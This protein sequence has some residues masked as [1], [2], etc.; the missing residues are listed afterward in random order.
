ME[1]VYAH[2]PVFENT[3]YLIRFAEENDAADL[4]EV[5]SDKNALPFFN[6]DNCNGDN[7]YYPTLEAM[8]SA[9]RFWIR[10]YQ[11]RWFVRFA[12]IDKTC[13]KAIG[14]AEL[15]HR[16]SEDAFSGDGVLRLDLKSSYERENVIFD[17]LSLIVPPSFS[18]FSCDEII[19][20]APCYAVERIAAIRRFGFEQSEHLLIGTHDGY[21]YNGYWAI[22]N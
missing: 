21:A 17:L 16:D 20:K 3:R 7:F 5:Y 1:D 8:Q 11:T 9:I 6:S 19:T 22:H 14:T 4:L 10:S 15:F 13:S 18:L 12:V 2:C